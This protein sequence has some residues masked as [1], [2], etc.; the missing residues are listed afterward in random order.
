MV[1]SGVF[2][3]PAATKTASVVRLQNALQSLGRYQKDTSLNITADGIVGP[4]T[5]AAVNR[6]MR[7]F[8]HFG[9]GE[10]RTGRLTSTQ[11]TASADAIAA[12]IEQ[13]AAP[14]RDYL[15]Q[16]QGPS[17]AAQAA[18]AAGQ[19]AQTAQAYLPKQAY[20]AGGN[21]PMPQYAPAQY[22]PA[23]RGYPPSTYPSGYATQPVYSQRG[24]GG[25]PTDQATLDV[26]AFI[27]AQY[28]HIRLH[29]A[30]AMLIVAVGVMAAMLI[31][32]HKAESKGK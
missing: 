28:E 31:S 3:A 19:A 15:V 22:A 24:P 11:I 1:I 25:M 4:K 18:Q 12:S 2:G 7:N 23:V 5:T 8:V 20:S 10:L 27:P 13:A 14:G 9:P 6:A 30:G 16:P 21:V 17:V 32:K 29:P 26:K